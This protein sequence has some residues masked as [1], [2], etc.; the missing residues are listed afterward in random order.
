MKKCSSSGIGLLIVIILS[1]FACHEQA[2]AQPVNDLLVENIH[3]SAK[4]LEFSSAGTIRNSDP[5]KLNY[6]NDYENLY[7]EDQQQFLKA[8]IMG[9]ENETAIQ[10]HII[11]F[12]SS[13]ILKHQDS[14]RTALY[15]PDD[16]YEEN[17]DKNN[18]VLVKICVDQ[19]IMQIEDFDKSNRLITP[20]QSKRIIHSA[21]I[22]F[23]QRGKIFEGSLKGLNALMTTLRS[24]GVNKE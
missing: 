22:P 5:I 3:S 16:V 6:V 17:T 19:Q 7:S 18:I 10:I 9:F 13:M 20:R 8:L 23:F 11:T 4:E 1:L 2:A 21:F 12:D 15:F 24:K 14:S